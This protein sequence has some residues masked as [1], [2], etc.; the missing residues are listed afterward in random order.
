M[1]IGLSTAGDRDGRWATRLLLLS[2]ALLGIAHVAFLPPF[3]D[4]DEIGHWS[5]IQELADTGRVPVPAVDSLAADIQAYPGPVFNGDPRA[6]QEYFSGPVA[7]LTA[8]VERSYRPGRGASWEGQHAPLYYLLLAPFY[9]LAKD[10][11]WL[12][13]MLLLRSVSWAIAFAGFAI[14][15]RVSQ[16]EFERLGGPPAASLLIP[17][18]P[19]LFPQF[20]PEMARLGNDSLCLL[21]MSV[22]WCFLLRGLRSP[23]TRSAT[24]LGAA[25]GVGLLTK[26]FFWPIGIG[27]AALLAFVA[28]RQHDMR[29]AKL[30]AVG[31]TVAILIGGGWYIRNLVVA[32]SFFNAY[33][34]VEASQLGSLWHR[35]GMRSGS[36]ELA[37]F[38]RGFVVMAGSFAWAG[39]RTLAMLPR[40]FTAPVVLLAALPILSWLLRLKRLPSTGVAPLFLAAPLLAVLVYYTIMESAPG[41]AGLATPGWYLHILSAPL[42]LA[43]ALGWRANWLFRGLLVYA[44]AFH[45][46]CW[47]TQLSVF[48]GCAFKAGAHMSLRLDPGSCLIVPSHLAALGEPLLGGT[49]LLAAVLASAGALLVA[50]RIQALTPRPSG[51]AGGG[52]GEFPLTVPHG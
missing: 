2:V 43:L 3:E 38:L 52:E 22:V 42:A 36:A 33:E 1:T 24:G 30:A 41:T 21:V 37:F 6:Y 23:D 34:V 29:Y 26:A 31:G 9:L 8:P 46:V 4:F 19:L 10:W 45:V 35:L 48:S 17:A 51:A 50:R 47:G 39:T 32:G 40:I 20:F 13:H 25:L 5:Y 15:C 27:C 18:W 49:A 11:G 28:L 44:L 16:R 12:G 7:D 14:G